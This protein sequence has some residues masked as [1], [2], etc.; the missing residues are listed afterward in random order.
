MAA[1]NYIPQRSSVGQ[2]P[3]HGNDPANGKANEIRA[4]SSD[5]NGEME[6][7]LYELWQFVPREKREGGKNWKIVSRKLIPSDQETLEELVK[8]M[9]EETSAKEQYRFLSPNKRDRITEL[10]NEHNERD[11]RYKWRYVYIDTDTSK[12]KVLGTYQDITTKMD[13]ILLR[14]LQHQ[15]MPAGSSPKASTAGRAGSQNSGVPNNRSGGQPAL[16]DMTRQA[17]YAQVIGNGPGAYK[18]AEDRGVP[19]NGGGPSMHP[20]VH[21]QVQSPQY[22]YEQ[23]SPH[24]Q[25]NAQVRLQGQRPAQPGPQQ[26]GHPQVYQQMQN[27]M[28]PEANYAMPQ[29]VQFHGAQ[30]QGMQKGQ[31]AGNFAPKVPHLPNNA[32]LMS[33]GINIG[34]GP[35]AR[36][37]DGARHPAH[38]PPTPMYTRNSPG[39]QTQNARFATAD[40]PQNARK[41]KATAPPPKVV[42]VQQDRKASHMQDDSSFMT[43]DESL[44]EEEDGYSSAASSVS[45]IAKGSLHREKRYMRRDMDNRGHR[46]HYRKQSQKSSGHGGYPYGNVDI[47]PSA[48]SHRSRESRRYDTS[49]ASNRPVTVHERELD[50]R[51]PGLAE[52]ELS[53]NEA[54][55]RLMKMEETQRTMLDKM[56]RLSIGLQKPESRNYVE[57]AVAVRGIEP[58]IRHAVP[59]RPVY[60][61]EAPMPPPRLRYMPREMPY[62][63]QP[64]AYERYF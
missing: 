49:R 47:L 9:E 18:A 37:G 33:G 51:A 19:V 39:M 43:E 8:T 56:D 29:G 62:M 2:H 26:Q 44:F 16:D 31:A 48:S 45:S 40:L 6:P 3:N 32:P 10:L 61:M 28:P 60:Y 17:D 59:A 23:P 22:I 46:T 13:V 41:A 4:R 27:P 58:E 24:P 11:S 53:A 7:K 36:N 64:Y 38:N 15:L 20:Q 30:D 35:S 57:R 14:E 5:R 50:L 52:L 21:P 63:P 1:F 42:V 55:Y 25:A 54:S 34:P 12:V